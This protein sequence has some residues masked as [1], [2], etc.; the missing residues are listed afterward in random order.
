ML[1]FTLKATS[2]SSTVHIRW[3]DNVGG[4]VGDLSKLQKL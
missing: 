1:K 2:I 3:P 4:Y